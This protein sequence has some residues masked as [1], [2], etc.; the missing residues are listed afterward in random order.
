M[1]SKESP[2][3]LAKVDPKYKGGIFWHNYEDA[4][5][6][7]LDIMSK[8]V[9]FFRGVYA[10]IQTE[11]EV[12]LLFN[13]STKTYRIFVPTQTCGGGS[14]DYKFDA[15]KMPLGYSLVGSIHS[16]PVFSAFH[17]G[18]DTHDAKTFDGLH[19]TVGQV[20]DYNRIEFASM[21]SLAGSNFH[22]KIEEVADV[23]GLSDVEVPEWWYSLVSKPAAQTVRYAAGGNSGKSWYK[24]WT[25]SEDSWSDSYDGTNYSSWNRNATSYCSVLGQSVPKE[26]MQ[27]G[28]TG[29]IKPQMWPDAVELVA[30]KLNE[31]AEKEGYHI[32]FM[33]GKIIDSDDDSSEEDALK[34]AL[35][36]NTNSGKSAMLNAPVDE[37]EEYLGE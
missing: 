29:K 25:G 13:S 8:V 21:I 12:M 26:W 9:S 31:V 18:T 5:I 20:T 10:R 11:A 23:E 19:I 2:A 27:E 14:V 15:T 6:V 17:S 33:V 28:Y 7:P 37:V 32:E 16:H 1:P 35:S 3:V 4:P 34:I 24:G 22:Q 36:L 30:Q